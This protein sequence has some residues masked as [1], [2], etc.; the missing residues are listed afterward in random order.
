MAG[1]LSDLTQGTYSNLRQMLRGLSE[2]YGELEIPEHLYDDNH[3]YS[4]TTRSQ[5]AT[6]TDEASRSQWILVHGMTPEDDGCKWNICPEGRLRSKPCCSGAPQSQPEEQPAHNK[7]SWMQSAVIDLL[8][9][10]NSRYIDSLR[11]DLANRSVGRIVA[12]FLS[13]DMA[14][15]RW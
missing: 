7:D 15:A 6:I 14:P 5:P 4:L 11:E 13:Q 3:T 12:N 10:D 9:F 8:Q 1:E 2:V